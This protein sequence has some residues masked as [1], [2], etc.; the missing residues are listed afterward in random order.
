M[1]TSPDFCQS[2]WCVTRCFFLLNLNVRVVSYEYHAIASEVWAFF[3]FFLV[4]TFTVY[5]CISL[6]HASATPPL[7]QKKEKIKTVCLPVINIWLGKWVVY[8]SIFFSPVD[9]FLAIIPSVWWTLI[10]SLGCCF[11]VDLVIHGELT[12]MFLYLLREI[13]TCPREYW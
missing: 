5:P 4:A 2:S 10:Y 13:Q 9:W 6:L 8:W 12:E 7:P 11:D 1:M 3:K